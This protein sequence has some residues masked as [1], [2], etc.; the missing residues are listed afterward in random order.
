[1]RIHFATAATYGST[2]ENLKHFT[3]QLLMISNIDT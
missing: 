3:S 2:Q 1:M